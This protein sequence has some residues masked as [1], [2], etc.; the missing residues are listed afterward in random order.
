MTWFNHHAARAAAVALFLGAAFAVP[1]SA[2][3]VQD[4]T[5]LP[6]SAPA[7][8]AAEPVATPVSEPAGPRVRAEIPRVE[9]VMAGSS[10]AATMKKDS[11]H[12]ITISTLV[13]V[14]LVIVIVL[15]VA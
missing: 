14:L 9:P 6:A 2:Q 7:T 15:L 10:S 5:P 4:I 1:A 3:R 13:L 12:T 11:M 8:P